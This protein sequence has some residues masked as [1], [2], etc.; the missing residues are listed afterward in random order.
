VCALIGILLLT[1]ILP[2][3]PA[4]LASAV[5]ALALLSQLASFGS[6]L[7]WLAGLRRRHGAEPA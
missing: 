5:A 7:A 3:T 1:A 6:D 2:P 4:W